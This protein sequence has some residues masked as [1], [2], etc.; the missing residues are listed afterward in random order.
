MSCPIFDYYVLIVMREH[1][2]LSSDLLVPNWVLGK[3]AAFDLSVSHPRSILLEAS[4]IT[5]VTA[6]T[7]EQRKHY[8]NDG[9]WSELGWVCVLSSG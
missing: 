9:K 8:F 1:V 3:P 4:M 7:A 6:W 5:G 2:I